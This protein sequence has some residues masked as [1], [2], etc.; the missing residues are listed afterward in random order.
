MKEYLHHDGVMVI[1]FSPLW[2]SPYGGHI[3]YLTKVPYAHLLFPEYVSKNELD[4]RF[5]D[6]NNVNYGQGIHGLNKM[7]YKRFRKIIRESGL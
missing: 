5:R 3:R 2:K 6:R 7:T 4:E 1:G